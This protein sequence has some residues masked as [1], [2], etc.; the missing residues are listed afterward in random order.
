MYPS[1]IASTPRKETFLL[2]VRNRHGR[3]W[4]S[5]NRRYRPSFAVQ[6]PGKRHSEQF[7]HGGSNIHNRGLLL[8]DL[9][10]REQH[11]GNQ[12]RI[13]AVVAT[14][15][16]EIVLENLSR[17]FSHDRIPRGSKTG[18]VANDQIWSVVHIRARVGSI[19]I[20]YVGDADLAGCGIGQS[21]KPGLQI[22][23]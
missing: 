2:G 19:A 1:R 17:N 21:I 4:S 22:S 8:R 11:A 18:R 6:I 13:N 20:E 9:T 15:S 10:V 7:Q 12:P 16:L 23:F 5:L 3:G 14:P